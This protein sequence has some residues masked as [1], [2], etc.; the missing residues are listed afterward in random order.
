MTGDP[1]P[2][3]QA[4]RTELSWERTALGALGTAAL[5]A[6]RIP[7]ASQPVELLPSAAAVLLALGLAVT[8]RRRRQQLTS[9]HRP[10]PAA[11]VAVLISG[12]SVAGLGMMVSILSLL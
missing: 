12:V 1:P 9:R 8:G 11:S 4:E 6:T 10:P 2:G 3:L 7:V 5:L